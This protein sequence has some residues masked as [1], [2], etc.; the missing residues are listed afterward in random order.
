M[1]CNFFSG[2][3]S[4]RSCDGSSLNDNENNSNDSGSNDDQNT[5]TKISND[6]HLSN[7]GGLSVNGTSSKSEEEFL[8]KPL[9]DE[10]QIKIPLDEKD[11]NDHN[12][13]TKLITQVSNVRTLKGE[14]VENAVETTNN[15]FTNLKKVFADEAK[16]SV[17]PSSPTPSNLSLCSGNS[18]SSLNYT[19]NNLTKESLKRDKRRKMKTKI[20]SQTSNPKSNERVEEK[21]ISD[22]NFKQQDKIHNMSISTKNKDPT[23]DPSIKQ[24]SKTLSIHTENKLHGVTAVKTKSN[25]QDT[26]SSPNSYSC[27]NPI[28]NSRRRFSNKLGHKK[29][30]R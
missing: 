16:L 20:Q 18:S 28:G 19:V 12:Q 2:K 14:V 24:T 23:F 13:K 10:N 6:S 26:L 29:S 30:K 11:D 3:P 15:K 17:L 21:L 1:Y 8:E 5:Y 7:A 22:E 4:S 9:I 25:I 27:S